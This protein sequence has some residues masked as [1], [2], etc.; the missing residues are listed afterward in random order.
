ME[1]LVQVLEVGNILTG[2]MEYHDPVS[3]SDESLIVRSR[4][5]SKPRDLCCELSMCDK[6]DILKAI[7]LVIAALIDVI[8]VYYL[9]IEKN[10]CHYNS[11][12]AQ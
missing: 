9:L 10:K 4:K 2:V 1:S 5:V 11:L 3:I 12:A 6:Y 8:K 7:Y